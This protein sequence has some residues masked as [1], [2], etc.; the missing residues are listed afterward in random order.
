MIRL[1]DILIIIVIS[2]TGCAKKP[3]YPD[4]WAYDNKTTTHPVDALTQSNR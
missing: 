3:V 1:T 4:N 2:L